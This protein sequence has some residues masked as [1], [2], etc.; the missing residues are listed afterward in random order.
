MAGWLAKKRWTALKSK[1][2]MGS[3]TYAI[4]TFRTSFDSYSMSQQH[5]ELYQLKAI[6]LIIALP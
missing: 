1:H 2:Q 4:T 3:N 6:D 5:I